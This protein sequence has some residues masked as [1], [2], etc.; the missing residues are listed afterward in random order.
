MHFA[1]GS[2][3]SGS[4]RLISIFFLTVAV[5]CGARDSSTPTAAIGA[6]YPIT[7]EGAQFEKPKFNAHPELEV[8]TSAGNF[9]L[10]LDAEAA[11][12][13]VDNFLAYVDDGHYNGTIF[14]QVYPG[15]IVLGGG[16]DAQMHLKPTQF[17]VRNEAHNGLKNARGT[18]AMARQSDVIDSATSQF[19]I[20]IADNPSLNHTGSDASTYGYCVFGEVASG[21]DVVDAI[22]KGEVKTQPPFENLPVKP[23]VIESIRRIN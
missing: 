7:P 17:P 18:I 19:F 23:V 11:P 1:H 4:A 3:F 8:R 10:K 2:E 20:N 14:H 5:G 15:Y 13:T 22:A 16:Y 6:R 9:T 21:L 12:L